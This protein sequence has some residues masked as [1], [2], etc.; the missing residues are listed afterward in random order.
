MSNLPVE[1][2]QALAGIAPADVVRRVEGLVVRG[3][4]APLQSDREIGPFLLYVIGDTIEEVATKTG[5]PVDVVYLTAIAFRWE[6]KRAA[7]AKQGNVAVVTALQKQLVNNLLI[8]T[9]ASI[10]RQVGEVMSGRLP[11]EKCSLIPRSLQGLKT[12]LE[13]VKEV[14]TMVSA[15]DTKTSTNVIHA[16]NVQINQTVAP[17]EPKDQMALLKKMAGE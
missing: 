3:Q 12:L 9:Q 13:M 17:E 16:E 6:E 4:T 2:K 7:L 5:I 8:A 10:L 15:G 1:W 11:P 14:N